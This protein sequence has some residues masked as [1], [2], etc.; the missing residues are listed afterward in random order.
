MNAGELLTSETR[1]KSSASDSS[2]WEWEGVGA[3]VDDVSGLLD[4]LIALLL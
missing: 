3:V 4:V 2:F 1:K